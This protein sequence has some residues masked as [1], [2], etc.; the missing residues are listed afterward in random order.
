MT[1]QSYTL[2]EMTVPPGGGTPLHS[3]PDTHETFYILEG[4]IDLK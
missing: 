4:E 1:D 2:I 3:H